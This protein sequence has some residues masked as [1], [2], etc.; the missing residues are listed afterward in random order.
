[1]QIEENLSRFV[2]T[3]IRCYNTRAPQGVRTL[4]PP[5]V[6]IH[7]AAIA[8]AEQD[9]GRRRRSA[10]EQTADETHFSELLAMR[11]RVA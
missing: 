5:G 6:P 3:T 11:V 10:A 9:L 4:K 1:M 2:P 8:L 7:K